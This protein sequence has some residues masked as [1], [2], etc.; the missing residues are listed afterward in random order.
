MQTRRTVEQY[1][2]I[3]LSLFALILIVFETVLIRAA[4][5]WFPNEPWTVSLTAAVTAVVMVRWGPWAVTHAVLGGIVF[6]VVNR[7]QWTQFLIYGLG[8]TAALAVWPL[9]RKLGWKKIN[10]DF[11]LKLLYSILVV[12]AMQAGRAL[13]AILLGTAPETAL[14]FITTDVATY[15]FTAVILWIMSR[16]DGML[17]DQRHYL[18]RINDPKNREGGIA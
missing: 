10:E 5:G 11:L 8:N 14:G 18:E 9:V 4:A 17:E 1:R 7:G 15:I 13:V 16:L 2:A 3:D 12:L 6:C